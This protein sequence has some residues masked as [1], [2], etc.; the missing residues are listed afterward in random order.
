MP[1]VDEYNAVRAKLTEVTYLVL[2]ESMCGWRP[3]TSATGGLPN[4]TFE[5]RKPKNLGTM[6]KNGAEC[7][8]GFMTHHDIVQ[9]PG[10]QEKKGI[11]E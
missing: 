1:F 10:D 8:T 9:A 2:N 11:Y 7:I 5:P 3:K 4:I 6:V